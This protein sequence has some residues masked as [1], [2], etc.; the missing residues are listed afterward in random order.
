MTIVDT[1]LIN[2][3]IENVPFAEIVATVVDGEEVYNSADNPDN[4]TQ[5][6]KFEEFINDVFYSKK[7]D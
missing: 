1:D 2:E 5:R 6:Q 4:K 3:K 7:Y